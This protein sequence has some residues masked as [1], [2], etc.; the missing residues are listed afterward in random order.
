MPNVTSVHTGEFWAGTLPV[1][2]MAGMGLAGLLLIGRR[3]VAS[4]ARSLLP[5]HPPPGWLMS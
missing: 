2:L 3:R 4:L 1:I 5:N